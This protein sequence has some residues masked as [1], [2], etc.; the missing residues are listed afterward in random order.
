MSQSRLQL[1]STIGMG[2]L[3][4]TSLIVIIPEG[5]ETLYSASEP[6]HTHTHTRRHR[7]S[8]PLDVRWQNPSAP[9]HPQ[10][11]RP[12]L[13]LM[14]GPLLPDSTSPDLSAL[15]P[16]DPPL[17]PTEPGKIGILEAQ[18]SSSSSSSAAP[19][20][21]LP[22]TTT[23]PPPPP[24]TH[25]SHTPHAWV[26]ISLIL[27]FI[28]MYL[29]DTLPTLAPSSTSRTTPNNIYSL[30][31]LSSS[32]PPF[33][34]QKIHRRSF[35]TTLGLVI[36][37]AADGIAMGASH[38]SGGSTG[39][40]FIIFLA[41]M[42]HK[43]PAAFGLT[44]VLLKQG[45]GKRGARAHLVVFSLA[46]PAGAVGTWV[47]V[48][49][50]GGGGGGADEEISTRWWTGVLLLFSGGTFL[51]VAMHTMRETDINTSIDESTGGFG[52]GYL[53]TAGGGGGGGQRRDSN[54]R[55]AKEGKS[56]RLVAAA[57]GGMLL[58]LLTQIGH[59]H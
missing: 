42:I 54:S 57:V 21:P 4:G 45:L 40:G 41:I 2:V 48:R 1:I 3:V 31:D 19:S 17:T 56:F 36:H 12:D 25:P 18:S 26:G 22:P 51:Y 52:N 9:R 59:A 50:L 11:D 49:M 35:S 30:S 7:F 8:Q 6:P 5:V 46:A 39:L 29:L 10:P 58:P 53:D 33:H 32:A 44:S 37:A 55:P 23:P 14:P 43:A 15:H 13:P 27:G 16:N 47:V 20:P 24:E 34:N 28:L 38:S